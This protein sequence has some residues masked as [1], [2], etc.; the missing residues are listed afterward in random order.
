MA[1]LVSES[2]L[3]VWI[4]QELFGSLGGKKRA[5]LKK[6]LDK[7]Q[8]LGVLDALERKIWSAMVLRDNTREQ[9]KFLRQE[10]QAWEKRT[11]P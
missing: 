10:L 9:R 4:Y 6:V 2:R 1:G 7:K 5:T 8:E 3:R 11:V